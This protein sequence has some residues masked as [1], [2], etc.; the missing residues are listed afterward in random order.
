LKRNSL[1]AVVALVLVAAGIYLFQSRGGGGP[2]S[3]SSVVASVKQGT[4]NSAKAA[5]AVPQ[6]E[7]RR[8]PP[9]E[10]A[11]AR[12]AEAVTQLLSVGTLASD[13]SVAIAAEVPG[14]ISDIGFREGQPVEAGAVL[15]KLD[16]ALARAELA[17]AE[18]TL[19]LANSNFTRATSLS[20]SGAGTQRARD[21]ALSALETA[22]AAQELARVRLDKTEVRAPFAGVVGLRNVSV[23]AY[24]QIGQTLVNLEKIDTLKLDFRL[25]EINLQDVQVGQNLEIT[26]DAFPDRKFQ[27]TVYAIDPLV[28]ANGRAL[29]IR[30]RLANP[31]NSLRPGLFAR[32]TLQGKSRGSVVLIPEGAIV[33]RGNDS[34]VFT[35]QDGTASEAKVTLGRR[36]NGEV[37][38]LDGLPADATV[39]VAGQARV[40]SGQQVEVV[41]PRQPG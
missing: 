24:V 19:K 9:V 16:S 8:A 2:D 4:D 18:S 34:F 13:E 6:G 29:K 25:P 12:A 5:P 28:D 35:V 14:R 30:A 33:P 32:V 38:V 1:I 27:A 22:R 21:E 41:S 37:E 23:G 11:P 36:A 20:Q 39:V 15:V 31:D 26:I 10:V 7:T 3:G 17:E 40:R